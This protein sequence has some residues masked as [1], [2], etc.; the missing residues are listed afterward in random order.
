ME[1]PPSPLES[2]PSEFGVG[3]VDQVPEIVKKVEPMYPYR[4][5][6]RNI[7]GE[8]VVRF[9]V[10][11]AGHVERPSIVEARPGGVFEKSVLQAV[12]RWRFK[13]GYF[14]GKPVPTWVVLPIRFNL[15]G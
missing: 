13:P 10:S 1:A 8:V 11:A 3:D 9:L 4:A 7:H 5:R 6:R 15:N 2:I 14:K 12:R